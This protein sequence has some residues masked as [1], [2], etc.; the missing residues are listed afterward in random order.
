MPRARRGAVD[1]AITVS[2]NAFIAVAFATVLALILTGSP[3][4]GLRPMRAARLILVNL[5]NPWMMTGSPLE[6]TAVTTS[7]RP[8][9]TDS[10]S[11]TS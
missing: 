2:R 3:V 5:A 9:R 6:T 8:A 1:G 4:W 7:V 10:T 11:F